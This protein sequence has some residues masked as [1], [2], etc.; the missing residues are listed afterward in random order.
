MERDIAAAGAA[1]VCGVT[2]SRSAGAEQPGLVQHGTGGRHCTE[3]GDD[4]YRLC[5][6]SSN[7]LILTK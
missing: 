3:H 1:S 4:R 2:R 7:K 6:T 5:L